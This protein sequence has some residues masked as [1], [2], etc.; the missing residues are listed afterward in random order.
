MLFKTIDE[1]KK[2]TGF[3]YAQNN[4][5]N[6]TTDLELA[7]ED[8]RG[9]VGDEIIDAALA[10]YDSENY[11]SQNPVPADPPADPPVDPP[12]YEIWTKL[13]K[14]IQLPVAYFAIHSFY[15]NTDVSHEDTGRKVKIDA[16]REKLPWE[17]ML[18]KDEKAILKKAHRT[19]D[20]LINFLEQNIDAFP[21]WAGSD[22]RKEIRCQFI[23]SATEFHTVYPIDY[24]R[25]FFLTISPF[26]REAERK[27]IKPVL[28]EDVFDVMKT[29]MGTLPDPDAEPPVTA[30]ADTDGLL[31]LIRVPLALYAMSIAVTRLSLEVLPEGVF[32]NLVSERLTQNAKVPATAQDR[33]EISK[34]LQTRA[35]D[36]L[37]FLQEKIRKIA[38]ASSETEF[39]AADLTQGLLE[40]NK[41]ARM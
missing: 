30:Y 1:L 12:N 23:A 35:N 11:E 5:E 7:E 18:E 6:I 22:A 15:Q 41:F 21:E 16:E 33:F 24:S 34:S 38:A 17:W 8:L 3:L 29:A 39:I 2:A 10:H 20:R 31:P 40:T 9:V 26:I 36:E 25:R 28:G 14:Y 37:R 13:V 32:Q 27:Y 19:T 4:I